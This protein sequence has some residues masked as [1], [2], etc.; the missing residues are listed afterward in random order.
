MSEERGVSV[1]HAED[2]GIVVLV[3]NGAFPW[4][5]VRGNQ[6]CGEAGIH[7]EGGTLGDVDE[8]VSGCVELEIALGG[9]G[10]VAAVAVV[11]YGPHFEIAEDEWHPA[12][13]VFVV[14]GSDE[15]IDAG[16]VQLM[17]E[18]GCVRG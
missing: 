13:V 6:S 16:D 5:G 10:I 11:V 14:V 3:R 9:A 18:G 2:E 12:D 4:R 1:N 17:E 8:F 15:I 7:L